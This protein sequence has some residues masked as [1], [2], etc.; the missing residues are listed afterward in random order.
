MREIKCLGQRKYG[1]DKRNY[2]YSVFECPICKIEVIRKRKDG[3]RQQVCSHNCYATTRKPRGAY[4]DYVVINGYIYVYNPIHPKATK[5]G[6]IAEH[7]LIGEK[8]V[9][10]YLFDDE[11]VHHI[12][13]D[14]T[15]NREENLQVMTF[16]EHSH[17]HQSIKRRDESGKF[18]I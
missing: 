13:L 8:I 3:L 7:R 2:L 14:K 11:V 12:N 1:N 6:Y 10:R 4:K 9:G 18:S 17:L 5:L 16:S 15:D